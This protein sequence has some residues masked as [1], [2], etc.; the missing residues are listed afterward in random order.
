MHSS[1]L[2]PR[3]PSHCFSGIPATVQHLLT[4]VGRPGLAKGVLDG[5]AA[6][7]DAVI[8]FFVDAFGWRFFEEY[9]DDYPFLRRFTKEGVVSQLTSQFPSTT[10]AHVTTIH[11]GLPVGQSGIFEWQYYEPQ[12]DAVIA[13]LLFSFA[14]TRDRDTLKSH[15][16]DPRTLYP[17]RTFYQALQPYGV[18]SYV[19]QHREYTPS[20]FSDIMFEGANVVPYKTLPEALVNLHHLLDKQPSPSYFFL[21]YDRIDAIC[22]D[23]GP[24]SPQA[25]GE[26]DAFLT[27][28]ERLFYKPALRRLKNTLFILTA[29]HGQIEIDP[30][31]TIY[32]NRHPRFAGFQRYLKTNRRGEVLVPGG[33]ARDVFLYVKDDLLDEALPFFSE[34]LAGRAEVHPVQQ[35][36]AQGFFGP[37][38]VSQALLDRVGNLVIL[39]YEYQSVWWYEKGKFEQRFYGHHGGLTRQEMEIP[40]LL[41]SI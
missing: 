15:K 18:T 10:A 9:G 35:L 11:T 41:Y 30:Q 32:L 39:P 28:M 19:F 20:T 5:L 16:V 27:S 23:Y 36:I 13:P 22:H 7:Y 2:K 1:F 25:E 34:R 12:L 40:F 24:D 38:P 6:R 8:L 3:Y 21:Y 4:G 31:T 17:A 33:S 37:A 26:I 29:D 14:G